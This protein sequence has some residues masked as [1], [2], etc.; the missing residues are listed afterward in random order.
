MAAVDFPNT[1]TDGQEFSVNGKTWVW[2]E[3]VQVWKSVTSEGGSG[4][5]TVSEAAPLDPG[6]GDLWFNSFNAT[7]YIYYD[8]FWVELSEGRNGIDAIPDG[9]QTIIAGQVFG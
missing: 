1:P 3:S 5:I 2:N 6:Q 4:S 9:D 8:G 7:T